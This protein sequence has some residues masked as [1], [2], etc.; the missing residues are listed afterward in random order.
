MIKTL[1][2]TE[3]AFA[4]REKKTHLFSWKLLPEGET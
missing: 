4:E 2:E 3:G 1:Q